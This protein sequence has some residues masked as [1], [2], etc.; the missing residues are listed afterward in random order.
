MPIY[1]PARPSLAGA[2][3]SAR[4]IDLSTRLSIMAAAAAAAAAGAIRSQLPRVTAVILLIIAGFGVPPSSLLHLA[5][6]AQSSSA[7]AAARGVTLRVDGR[8][9]V[10]SPLDPILANIA[11]HYS[12]GRL[13]SSK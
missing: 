7:K 1:I 4:G 6:A 12:S 9:Q 11:V 13:A 2:R 3:A 5:A 10:R 8:H